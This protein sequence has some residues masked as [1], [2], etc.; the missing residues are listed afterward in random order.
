[1]VED[2]LFVSGSWD[3]T[4]KLWRMEDGGGRVLRAF[5]SGGYGYRWIRSVICLDRDILVS[6]ANDQVVQMWRVSSG[7]CLQTLTGHSSTVVGVVRL[8]D[9]LFVSGSWSDEQVRVWDRQGN[10]V[11][12][13]RT[14]DHIEALTVL[15]DGSLLL[16]LSGWF[17]I[18]RL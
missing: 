3:Q 2:G 7:E 16:A 8:K 17:E 12:T 1:M 15:S 13:I 14:N 5:N 18:R 9:G 11:E 4:L 6:G 10:H